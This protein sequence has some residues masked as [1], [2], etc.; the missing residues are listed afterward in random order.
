M[1]TK[2]YYQIYYELTSIKY[3]DIIYNSLLPISFS[4]A[5]NYEILSKLS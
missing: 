5:K 2:K 4:S 1:T 3:E